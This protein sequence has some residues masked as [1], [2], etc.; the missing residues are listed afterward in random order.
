MLKVWKIVMLG[1]GL[2]NGVEDMGLDGPVSKGKLQE[3][4]A[5]DVNGKTVQNAGSANRQMGWDLTFSSP[6][7]VSVVWAFAD[8]EHK[9]EIIEAHKEAAEMAY[10]YIQ[11]KIT[12]R[13]G[14]GGA[15][16]EKAGIITA[17]FTHFTSREGDPQLHSHFVTPNISTRQDGT[18]GTIES[19]NFYIYKMAAGALY[20]A[21][22]AR[23]MQD[24]GYEVEDGV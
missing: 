9:D 15:I 13:R 23:N 16:K 6:K 11:N 22:F 2:G 7:S 1:N 12:T 4:L 19:K 3:A 17:H 20:Q 14:K 10:T 18:V 24:L 5:G 21:Q 8:N